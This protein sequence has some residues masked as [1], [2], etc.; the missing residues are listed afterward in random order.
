[1]EDRARAPSA[2]AWA[3]VFAELDGAFDRGGDGAEAALF[4]ERARAHGYNL[5]SL[6]VA[7]VA[8]AELVPDVLLSAELSPTLRSGSTTHSGRR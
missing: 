3:A 1:M 2:A 7:L 6:V 4:V 8:A 5:D